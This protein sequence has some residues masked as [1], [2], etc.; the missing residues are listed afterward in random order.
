MQLC[1]TICVVRVCWAW[2]AVVPL[3]GILVLSCWC[4]VSV[5]VCVVCVCYVSVVCCML[6]NGMEWNGIFS[7]PTNIFYLAARWRNWFHERKKERRGEKRRGAERRGEEGRGEERSNC[8]LQLLNNQHLEN[9]TVAQHTKQTWNQTHTHTHD[10][11]TQQEGGEA[12]TRK[13]EQ[14]RLKGSVWATYTVVFLPLLAFSLGCRAHRVIL[15]C[16]T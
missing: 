13:R 8:T 15:S 10:R 7:P 4:I 3:S 5:R 2:V 1:H 6:R 11:H 14:L 9:Y 12:N 16:F